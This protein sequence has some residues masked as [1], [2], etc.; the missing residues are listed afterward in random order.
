MFSTRF[1]GTPESDVIIGNL[2]MKKECETLQ[3]SKSYPNHSS[4]MFAQDFWKWC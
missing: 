1:P 4:W 2:D 3:E